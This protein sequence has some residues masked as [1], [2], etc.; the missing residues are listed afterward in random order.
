[1]L[2]D[3]PLRSRNSRRGQIEDFETTATM[4][5]SD[6]ARGTSSVI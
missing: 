3:L 5:R 1:M 4:M 6:I 2:A